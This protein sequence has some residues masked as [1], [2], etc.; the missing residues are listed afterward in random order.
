MSS[1]TRRSPGLRLK[2]FVSYLLVLV[3]GVGTLLLVAGSVSPTFFSDSMGHMMGG[4]GGMMGGSGGMPQGLDSALADAFRASLL[5]GLLIAAGVALVAAIAVS[6]FVAGRIVQPVR[7]LATASRRLAEGRYMERVPAGQTDELGELAQSFNDMAA[8][9]EAVERRRLELVGDV[10]HELRT[11]LATLQGNIEGLLDGVV[12]ASPETWAKL[13]DEVGR[14]R[15]LVD[16]LQELSR[17]E[18]RQIP[19]R[20]EPLDPSDVVAAAVERVGGSF[21]EKSIAFETEVPPRLPR[22]RADRDRAIQVLTNL[23][24][25]A[26]RYTPAQ[27]SVRMSA[28][29]TDG[30]VR[31][32]VTDSGMGIAPEDLPRVFERFYRT[33]K[34][35]SRAVGGSGIGL[36]ISRALVEAMG[37]R[38]WAESPGPGLGATF[39]FELPTAS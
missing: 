13:D 35:R 15:R 21:E 7:R 33:D 28:D 27:G 10:A 2:L 37:G 26:L 20:V 31:F 8:E 5:R 38:I 30:A 39:S 1:D 14:L 19:L 23:L 36:T 9:L 18:A 22:M 11:P 17:S 24:S 12:P 25:N 16:D 4:P 29:A 32:A 6:A 34:S 3:V